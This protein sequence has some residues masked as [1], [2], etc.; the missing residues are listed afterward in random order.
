MTQVYV[1]ESSLR[2]PSD[3]S[4]DPEAAARQEGWAANPLL[5]RYLCAFP[6]T[7]AGGCECWAQSPHREDILSYPINCVGTK[8]LKTD[9]VRQQCIY[10]RL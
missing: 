9:N 1:D 5:L 2:H 8:H 3:Q 6:H 7:A 10:E 4:L